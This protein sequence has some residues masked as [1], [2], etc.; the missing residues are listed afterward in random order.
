MSVYKIGSVL[1]PVDLSESS[2]NALDTAVNIAKKHR[3]SL[4][5]LYVDENNFQAWDDI[6]STFFAISINN[7]DVIAEE[8]VRYANRSNPDLVVVAPA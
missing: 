1:V 7:T 6:G 5:I 3:A 8:I 2:W 4:H